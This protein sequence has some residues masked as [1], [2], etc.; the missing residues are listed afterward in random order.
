MEGVQDQNTYQYSRGPASLR[1]AIDGGKLGWSVTGHISN[2]AEKCNHA[3]YRSIVELESDGSADAIQ[4][5]R[6][7]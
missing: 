6:G 2:L 4:R 7:G 3:S 1:A 5:N